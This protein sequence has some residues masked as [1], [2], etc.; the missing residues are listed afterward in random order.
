MSRVAMKQKR[1]TD[2]A[3]GDFAVL[4]GRQLE[5]IGKSSERHVADPGHGGLD[6]VCLCVEEVVYC[7]LD[8][9]AREMCA[10][11]EEYL[12]QYRH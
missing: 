3:T 1:N 12:A 11:G 9:V 2:L 6:E 5:E 8:E 7:D 4:V 10:A